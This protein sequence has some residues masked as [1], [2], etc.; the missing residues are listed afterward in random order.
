MKLTRLFSIRLLNL[1]PLLL[2]ALIVSCEAQDFGE[3]IEDAGRDI[4]WG[5]AARHFDREL[6]LS[7]PDDG[8]YIEPRNAAEYVIIAT[9]PAPVDPALISE[10]NVSLRGKDELNTDIFPD[11]TVALSGDDRRVRISVVVLPNQ[12]RY[13]VQLRNNDGTLLGEAVFGR[14]T[15]DVDGDGAV[16]L[17]DN[18]I[19][20]IYILAE[21][22][23]ANT[24]TVR[25][26]LNCDGIIFNGDV[27]LR[28]ANDGEDLTAPIPL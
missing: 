27:I 15:G 25:S 6:E 20:L 12:A 13:L 11:Y 21:I 16:G 3:I 7:V 14:L 18:N 4:R 24:L 2:A 10:A 9:L 22:T 26:D 1:L 8:S 17:I 23:A 28:T 5:I 19:L